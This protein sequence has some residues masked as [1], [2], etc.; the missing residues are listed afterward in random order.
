[1]EGTNPTNL[2][3]S[4]GSPAARGRDNIFPPMDCRLTTL[5]LKV[6]R[7]RVGV[8]RGVPHGVTQRQKQGRGDF[9]PLLRAFTL[10]EIAGLKRPV[11]YFGKVFYE[12]EP[13]FSAPPLTGLL[14]YG[15]YGARKGGCKGTVGQAFKCRKNRRR[16]K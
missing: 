14:C 16:G 6:A 4:G 7:S 11:Y 15:K 12:P 5:G 3:L 13:G 10:R 1:V 9:A 2:V 8:V